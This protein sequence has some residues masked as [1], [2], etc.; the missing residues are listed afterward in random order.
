[1]SSVLQPVSI[2]VPIKNRGSL[3]PN[4][5]KNLFNLN[6]PN[7]EIII[8]DDCST[9]NT[10][11]LLKRYPIKSIVLEKSVGSAEARNIGISKAK[12]DI[13]ALT[14]SDC[15]VSRNWLKDLKSLL[16]II[17]LSFSKCPFI[18]PPFGNIQTPCPCFFPFL[19]CPSYLL[20]S[21]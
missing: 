5:I 19:N 3:L 20:P 10:K 1:M 13:I 8:V 11:N 7:Y 2:I 15:F 21:E 14:D 16:R 9:D 4:L 18:M 12:N 6:Y 17:N